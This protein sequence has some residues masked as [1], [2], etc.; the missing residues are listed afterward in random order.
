LT[1]LLNKAAFHRIARDATVSLAIGPARNFTGRKKSWAT[2]EKQLSLSNPLEDQ[3]WA[4]MH[5]ILYVAAPRVSN[6]L[7]FSRYSPLVIHQVKSGIG[8]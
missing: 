6:D 5:T 8:V 3:P 7:L 1:K 4:T 2:A